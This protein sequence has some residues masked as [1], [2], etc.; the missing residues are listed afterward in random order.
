MAQPQRLTRRMAGL[1]RRRLPEAR[2]DQVTDPRARRGRRWPLRTLL[3]ATLL[4]LLAGAKSL[5][6][7]E[8]LTAE[9]SAGMRR[10]LRIYRRV[11][12]LRELICRLDPHQLRAALHRLVRAAQRRKAL[13]AD[14]LPFGVVALDGKATA[15][16]SCDDYYAQRQSQNDGRTLVGLLRTVTSALIS[17]RAR[18]CIDVLP[19][20][21]CTNE[22]GWFETALRHL[23]AA[24][25]SLDL[26][27]L[28]SYDAGACSQDNA[29]LVRELSLHYL[30]GLK[31]TQPTLLHEAQRLLASLGIGQ[32]LA[33]SEDD[34]GA[35]KR[36][37]RRL[38]L[39][40]QMA[41]FEWSHLR[42]VLRVES[43]T[44]DAAGRRLVY[45]NRYFVASL[46]ACR[47]SSKQWLLLVR[48]HWGVETCHN[49]L[50]TAFE[51]D[52]HPWIESEPRA[53][54]NVL[55][56]RRLAYD[57]LTLFRSVTQRS[58]QRRAT[59]W[60]TLMH[61]ID[62]ALREATEQDVCGLRARRPLCAT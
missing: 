8:A 37:L 58:E 32:A 48:R 29:S 36:V 35:G 47:L 15:L 6:E 28:V 20:A 53:A 59:P 21:A 31:S 2:L 51:E 22:M 3:G 11:A 33:D 19:I 46:P 26:F 45:E 42:T 52:K 43:E 17:C 44:L 14:G 39:T 1:L 34:L 38:Y 12:A 16:P 23:V 56:L 60:R 25:G 4:G 40:D 27:R 10:L 49:I 5:A 30:F 61:W 55:V 54:L 9:L 7:T 13:E 50:D 41:G 18:P 24:Y 57:L 62:R